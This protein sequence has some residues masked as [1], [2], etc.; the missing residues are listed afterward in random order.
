[1]TVSHAVPLPA[2][3]LRPA[4]LATRLSFL[5]AGLAMASWAPLIPFAKDRV[6]A[7]DAQLGILLLCLGIGSI[8]AMP[9]TGYISARR[10]ARG[11]V[12]LGGTGLVLL[13]P[14]LMTTDSPVLLGAAIFAFGASLGT[15]DVAMNVHAA[16]VERAEH[17]PMMSGFHA[18]W[19]VGGILG[20]GGTTALLWG[21]VPPL[22]AA[23]VAAGV[24]AASLVVAAPRLLRTRSGE[25]PVLALPRGLVLLLAVLAGLVFLVEGAILDWG[26][27][28]MLDRGLLPV[29]A[30]GL[31]FMLFSAAM[32]A[33]RLVGD[34]IVLWLGGRNTLMIGGVLAAA[35]LVLILTGG[36]GVAL[37]GFTLVGFG[38]AN[39]VP[40]LLSAAGRQ[41]V[42][43]PGL[44]IAA[45]TTVGYGGILLGPAAIGFVSE[46]TSLPT[47]FWGLAVLVLAVPACARAATR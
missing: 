22:G 21:G 35:G 9:V 23:L 43:A 34:R 11:M 8:I 28:L 46:A 33:G 19:S 25:P 18:M 31:G 41:K 27:L 39:L 20:A 26:A 37:G 2:T 13:L 30:G 29:E 47:A 32:A 6:G 44:A 17:R 24:S 45:I 14:L 40:V 38:C 15:I 16:E 5:A 1:M 4:A 10:G 42:M 12:L 3:G 7:S 36:A